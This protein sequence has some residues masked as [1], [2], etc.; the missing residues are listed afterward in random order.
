MVLREFT[1]KAAIENLHHGDRCDIQQGITNCDL[2]KLVEGCKGKYEISEVTSIE[3]RD[4]NE[5]IIYYTS[6]KRVR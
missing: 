1:L 4:G 2:K 5:D 6:I 3:K